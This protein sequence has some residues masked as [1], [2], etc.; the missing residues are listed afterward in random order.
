MDNPS[1][2]EANPTTCRDTEM[3][4]LFREARKEL[5]E[6]YDKPPAEL[7]EEVDR[8]EVKIVRLRDCLIQLLREEGDSPQAPQWRSALDRAN[9]ALSFVVGV[10]YPATGIHRQAL[11]EARQILQGLAAEIG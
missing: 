9:T 2:R 4:R 8:A 11:G 7:K 1:R 5:E 10:E 3:M 6:S